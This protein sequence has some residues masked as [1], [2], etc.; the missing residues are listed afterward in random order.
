MNSVAIFQYFGVA[1]KTRICK[2]KDLIRIRRNI[3][4]KSNP[5]DLPDAKYVVR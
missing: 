5:R 2:K 1:T 3:R 4:R